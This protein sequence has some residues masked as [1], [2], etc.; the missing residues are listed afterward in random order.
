VRDWLLGSVVDSCEQDARGT[1]VCTLRR[2]D[3]IRRVYWNPS[4][5]T[6]VEM[7]ATAVSV[8]RLGELPAATPTRPSLEVGLSP[9]MLESRS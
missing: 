8:W 3:R 7:P 4:T 2:S 6:T 1:Y 9:V 5:S